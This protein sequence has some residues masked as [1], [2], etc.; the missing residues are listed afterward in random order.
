MKKTKQ[1]R[2]ELEEQSYLLRQWRRWHRER[3]EALLIGPHGVALD[4]LLTFCKSM[5]GP[6][7]LIDYVK[8]GP[9]CDADAD[10]RAEILS[11]LDVFITQRREELGLPPF[12]DPPLPNAPP[13]AFLILRMLLR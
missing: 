2:K 12:D 4:A 8:A 3:V 7:A 10:V 1:Q 6:T 11:I 5:N 9:W 13:N